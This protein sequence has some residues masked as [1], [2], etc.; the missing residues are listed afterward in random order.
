MR[1]TV[2][3]FDLLE[4]VTGKKGIVETDSL[5]ET[6]GL[7]SLG[8][9]ML[10]LEVEEEFNIQLKESDMNPF[11]LQTVADLRD[12]VEKYSEAHHA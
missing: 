11:A 5:K 12:L 10:L 1:V 8:M 9:V 3:V 7:D 6:L 4:R 2:K